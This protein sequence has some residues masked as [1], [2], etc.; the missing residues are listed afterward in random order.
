M[1][2]ELIGFDSQRAGGLFTFGGT[3][4]LLYGIKIGL[5][6]AV[7]DV[8]EKGLQQPAV[9]LCSQQS[10]YACA[11][12]AGWLG[13][14]QQS[15]RKVAALADNGI[16][17]VELESAIRAAHHAGEKIAAIVATMGTT[18]AFGIDDLAGVHAL[19]ERLSVELQLDYRPHIHAD[20]VIGWAWAVFNQYDFSGNPLGFRGRT[21][22]ALAAAMRLTCCRY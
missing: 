22:R 18:D 13:L 12:A 15:V 10:H 2:A 19:R 20:A 6:K 5:E 7:P 21:L 1:I 14:G 11:T 8:F 3:G 17:L 4:T 16:D 9:I